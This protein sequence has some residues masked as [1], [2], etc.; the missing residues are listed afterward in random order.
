VYF[1]IHFLLIN[2]LIFYFSVKIASVPGEVLAE[3]L[4]NANLKRYRFLNLLGCTF[5]NKIDNVIILGWI[6]SC[7]AC[8]SDMREVRNA[9]KIVI[10]NL[11]RRVYLEDSCYH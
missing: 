1:G 5:T 11:K 10:R 2:V 6:I 4:L 8:V 7:V 3:N 9:Y